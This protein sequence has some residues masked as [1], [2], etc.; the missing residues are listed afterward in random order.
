[1]LA[2]QADPA[3]LLEGLRAMGFAPA[4]ES[5]EGDVLI[6][7]ADAHRTPPRTAPDPVPDGP[8]LPT[9]RCSAAAIRAIRAGDLA[10]TT[11]RKPTG[12]RPRPAA[13]PRTGPPRPSPP[14]RPPS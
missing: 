12:P 3:T 7:R 10:A 5:A 14:C 13:L 11:P 2:A 9:R 1:M 8:P 4:A 6:T